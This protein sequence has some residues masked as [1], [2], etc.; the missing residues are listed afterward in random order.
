MP[1]KSLIYDIL[2]SST[3]EIEN[4]Q[5]IV[6]EAIEKFN[7]TY[8]TALGINLNLKSWQN[9]SYSQSGGRPQELLN[10]QFVE[11][12]DLAIC[13]LWTRFGTPT[14]DYLSGTEEEIESMLQA[15][16]QVFL[17]FSD[18]PKSP[19]KIDVDQH[20]KVKEFRKKH[21]T[22]IYYKTYSSYDEFKELITLDL[23]LFF[24]H[25]KSKDSDEHTALNSDLSIQGI[26]SNNAHSSLEFEQKSSSSIIQEYESNYPPV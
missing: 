23:S 4:E 13:I 10:K 9:N 24:L 1:R 2:L 6:K 16:K 17:Y 21:E 19:S 15:G 20:N 7:S 8:A 25:L 26:S 18:I 14:G 12:C 5:S 22:S 3:S 11:D